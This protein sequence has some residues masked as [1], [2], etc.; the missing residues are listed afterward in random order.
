MTK[1]NVGIRMAWIIPNILMYI[2]FLGFSVFVFANSEGLK[3]INRLGI[4][5]V[6]LFFIIVNFTFRV[7]PNLV[8]DTKGEVVN[9]IMMNDS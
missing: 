2:L 4:W 9:S 1:P 5:F 8:L 7:L 6:I 3:D